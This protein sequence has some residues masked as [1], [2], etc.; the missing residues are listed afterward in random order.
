M[1]Q[2]TETFWAWLA[3][4]FDGEGCIATVIKPSPALWLKIGQ[5]DRRVLHHIK[6]N[7]G[8]GNIYSCYN[9]TWDSTTYI[10][11]VGR[12]E[13]SIRIYK[14]ILPYAVYKRKPIKLAV[15]FLELVDPKNRWNNKYKE[16]KIRL[17]K[18]IRGMNQCAS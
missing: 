13:D 17:I 4:F 9:K 2:E 5:K 6:K 10:Y 7:L 8:V 15:Q 14:H 18:K 1:K 3:G 11:A 16:E 12:K